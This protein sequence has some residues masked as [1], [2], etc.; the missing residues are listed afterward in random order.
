MND[1]MKLYHIQVLTCQAALHQASLPKKRDPGRPKSSA[2][3]SPALASGFQPAKSQTS[4]GNHR[5]FSTRDRKPSKRKQGILSDEELERE[6]KI[7]K[8]AARQR[9]EEV[10]TMLPFYR[11]SW[12]VTGFR[13]IWTG[14][15]DRNHHSPKIPA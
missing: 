6:S 7:L 13:F 15:C 14:K 11:T 3:Q 2:A 5:R 9:R 4:D 8:K 1:P 12:I 10:Y